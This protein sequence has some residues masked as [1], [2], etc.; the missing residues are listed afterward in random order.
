MSAIVRKLKLR[1]DKV[2]P[3]SGF[4]SDC[5]NQRPVPLPTLGLRIVN[6]DQVDA[7]IE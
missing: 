1:N 5:L 3:Q 2:K 4:M 7:A 6:P